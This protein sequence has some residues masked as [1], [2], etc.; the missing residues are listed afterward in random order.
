MILQDPRLAL[1]GRLA[2][3]YLNHTHPL[4]TRLFLLKAE[5]ECLLRAFR[6]PKRKFDPDQ[7]R[8]D[9]GRWTESGVGEA[10]D[11]TPI[12]WIGGIDKDKM[13]WTTQQFISH[14]CKANIRSVM[15][16]QFL[17]LTIS[18]IVKLANDGDAMARRCWKLL[19][20]DEYRK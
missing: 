10:P 9:I 8:D 17:T 7:P 16:G 3:D 4:L 2:L 1:S 18:E 20:Q 15:P 6:A 5:S 13:N 19:K 11:G 12:D 14:M